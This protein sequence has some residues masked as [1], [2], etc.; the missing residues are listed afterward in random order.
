MTIRIIASHKTLALPDVRVS[1]SYGVTKIVV[2]KAI[3]LARRENK[4]KGK[5]LLGRISRMPP[6]CVPCSSK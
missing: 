6:D 1:A 2:W 3:K 4:H 5:W